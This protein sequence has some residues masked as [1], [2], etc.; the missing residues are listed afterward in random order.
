MKVKKIKNLIFFLLSV[1]LYI[2]LISS[3]FKTFFAADFELKL[4]YLL[5]IIILVTWA[6]LFSIVENAVLHEL[7]H[8]IFGLIAG[9]KLL[10]V[11]ILWFKFDFEHGFK[12]KAEKADSL[13]ETVFLPKND[14]RVSLKVAVSI[15]GGLLATIYILAKSVY[16]YDAFYFP[17]ELPFD[18]QVFL[19]PSYLPVVHCQHFFSLS[20]QRIPF[21]PLRELHL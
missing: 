8:L 14:K 18:L 11:K 6:I 7:G 5:A 4:I 17:V 21:Q 1:G 16:F 2:L 19:E 10:S 9:L 3:T 20:K 13:G 15:L 12:I